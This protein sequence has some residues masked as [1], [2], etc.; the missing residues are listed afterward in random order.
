MPT[1]EPK[2]TL[3]D[4]VQE[5]L[6]QEALS[7]LL[8]RPV[9]RVDFKPM[10][11]HSGLAGGK[12]SYVLADQERLVLK[13]MSIQRDWIMFSSRDEQCRSVRLWQY[14]LL[15]CLLPHVEHKILACSRD[16]EGWAIL[17]RDLTGD[18]YTWD[19]PM[20]PR[21]VPVFLDAL[22]KLHALFWNDPLLQ[23]PRLGLCT[24]ALLL[25]QTS[26]PMSLKHQDA[27][28]GVIPEWVVRG[29]EVLPDILDPG[30]YRQMRAL[31]ENPAPLLNA[32][33]PFPY[34]L[35]HGDY[36]AE[37]L[38]HQRHPVFIDW[39]E[40][41]CSLMTFDLA[42]FAK[43]GYVKDTMGFTPAVRYYRTRLE[44]HLGRR[45]E[46]AAWQAMLDL[47]SAIDSLRSACFPAFFYMAEPDSDRRDWNKNMVLEHGRMV[48][49][50]LRWL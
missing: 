26:L 32:L 21:L 14:G 28:M 7:D 17:M 35:L 10:N 1:L 15:D 22:A 2:Y 4:S 24:P 9:A 49:D 41:S 39:Q 6:S 16:G 48:M 12:L 29:W 34:T 5:M 18:V 43:N 11:G 38:A 19:R 25:D 20:A 30:T 40:A 3:F 13:Q 31:I 47:G 50:A 44:A 37:N 33:A 8:A 23:D 42:W 46:D 27:S 36:R 45:F